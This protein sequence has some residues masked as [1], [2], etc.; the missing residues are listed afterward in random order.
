MLLA[1][2]DVRAR[3]FQVVRRDQ[4]LLDDVLD[5][6]YVRRLAVEAEHEH[7]AYLGSKQAGF[8][9]VELAACPAGAGKGVLDLGRVEW[10]AIAAL[11]SLPRGRCAIGAVREAARPAPCV[12][13]SAVAGPR[14]CWRR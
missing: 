8:L 11:P 14:S 5:L 9:R 2:D 10:G 3:R 4:R 6:F 7:L 1:I 12:T 13:R